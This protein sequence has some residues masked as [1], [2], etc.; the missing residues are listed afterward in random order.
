MFFPHKVSTPLPIDSFS[1]SHETQPQV[2]WILLP[3]SESRLLLNTPSH[4]KKAKEIKNK[5]TERQEKTRTAQ[6]PQQVGYHSPCCRSYPCSTLLQT[7]RVTTPLLRAPA[8]R[9]A[10]PEKLL[11]RCRWDSLCISPCAHILPTACGSTQRI[12]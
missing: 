3:Q 12:K 1:L 7:R 8:A 5:G 6:G 2:P 11:E 10:T 4:K 9:V